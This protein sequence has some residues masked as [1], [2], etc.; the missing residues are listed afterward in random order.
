M[1]KVN[2]PKLP[3]LN[4]GESRTFLWSFLFYLGK[5]GQWLLALV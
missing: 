2:D 5:Q 4:S 1:R 3:G